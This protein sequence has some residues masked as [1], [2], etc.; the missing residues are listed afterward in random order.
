MLKVALLDEP[1]IMLRLRRT[2]VDDG[3]TEAVKSRFESSLAPGEFRI[4]NSE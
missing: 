3:F 1:R 2:L 4:Q